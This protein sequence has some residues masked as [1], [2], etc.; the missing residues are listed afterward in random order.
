MKF[1]PATL[2]ALLVA[3][4]LSSSAEART[5]RLKG[6]AAEAF[7]SKN[8][9][10]ADIP[11]PVSGRFRYVDARGRTKWGEADCN[12]PAMGGRSE[13]DVTTCTVHY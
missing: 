6:A 12:Y 10:K 9:P 13:G 11:G 4:S 7:I 3:T 5:V 2:A 1:I 8:F